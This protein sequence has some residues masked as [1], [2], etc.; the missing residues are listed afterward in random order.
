MKPPRN[1]RGQL[2]LCL[3]KRDRSRKRLTEELE[4]VRSALEGNI[5]WAPRTAA[6]TLI[7][8]GLAAGWALARK[9]HNASSRD[10]ATSRRN[11]SSRRSVPP[12]A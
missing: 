11:A 8:L 12:S 4:E 5:G 9:L 7:L 10:N 1:R 3:Q 6:P 2:G